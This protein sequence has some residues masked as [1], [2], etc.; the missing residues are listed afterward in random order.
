MNAD[1]YLPNIKDYLFLINPTI[2]MLLMLWCCR[3]QKTQEYN[4]SMI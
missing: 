3:I 2:G 1:L 4:D